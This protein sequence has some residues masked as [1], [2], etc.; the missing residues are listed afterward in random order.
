MERSKLRPGDKAILRFFD[1]V[2]L[3]AAAEAEDGDRRFSVL[4][5]LDEL[6]AEAREGF[7]NGLRELAL[8]AHET[9]LRINQWVTKHP[10]YVRLVAAH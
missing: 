1:Q 6:E 9:T 8:W 5:Y 7:I 2:E 3:Q 4:R 10:D